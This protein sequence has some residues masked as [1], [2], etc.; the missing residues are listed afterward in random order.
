M[1]SILVLSYVL[2]FMSPVV[3]QLCGFLAVIACFFILF[4]HSVFLFQSL[5]SKQFCFFSIGL[6]ICLCAFSTV[7]FKE[8]SFVILKDSALLELLSTVLSFPSLSRSFGSFVFFS[9][10]VLSATVFFFWL[11]LPLHPSIFFFPSYF[12]VFLGFL[13][14]FL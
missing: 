1:F 3:W 11:F 9:V 13:Y 2:F 5:A 7:F 12:C 10:L 14:F 4:I 8:F 6:F